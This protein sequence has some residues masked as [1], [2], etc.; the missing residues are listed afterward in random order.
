METWDSGSWQQILHKYSQK[1]AVKR[2][3]KGGGEQHDEEAEDRI[4]Q[5]WP[6]AKISFTIFLIRFEKIL[7]S[8]IYF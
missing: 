8:V 5:I 4:R 1:E 7:I 6:A 2:K 3:G